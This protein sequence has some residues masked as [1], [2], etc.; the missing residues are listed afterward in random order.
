MPLGSHDVWAR[1]YNSNWV[2]LVTGWHTRLRREVKWALEKGPK[3]L[4]RVY[5]GMTF[6]SQVF[7]DY[8]EVKWTS[9]FILWVNHTAVPSQADVFF[10][11]SLVVPGFW[12]HFVFCLEV[13]DSKEGQ[14]SWICW[15]GTSTKKEYTTIMSCL[16]T[17]NIRRHGMIVFGFIIIIIIIIIITIIIIIIIIIIKTPR[18]RS[19]E[20]WPVVQQQHIPWQACSF[21]SCAA[22]VF[23]T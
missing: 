8:Y 7:G 16:T 5:R 2:K 12:Y 23:P 13:K 11:F 20:P 3:R 17:K 15:L 1:C 22:R 19:A 4:F 9:C 6:P 18:L 14:S 10:Y 21:C